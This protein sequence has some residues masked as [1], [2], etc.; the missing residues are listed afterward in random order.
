MER[1]LQLLLLEEEAAAITSSS[2]FSF[3]VEE[4]D[5]QYKSNLIINEKISLVELVSDTYWEVRRTP[6]QAATA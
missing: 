3:E 4:L 1:E 5:K 6:R 2:S